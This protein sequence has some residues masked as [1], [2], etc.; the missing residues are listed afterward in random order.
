MP[1]PPSDDMDVPTIRVTVRKSFLHAELLAP[2]EE[3]APASPLGR[4]SASS[5]P[6]SA[7]LASGGAGGSSGRRRCA[8]SPR[9]PS[10][11]DLSTTADDADTASSCSFAARS[12]SSPKSQ[13]SAAPPSPSTAPAAPPPLPRARPQ[14]RTRRGGGTQ[15]RRPSDASA[16][17][18]CAAGDSDVRLA[19][20]PCWTPPA[21]ASKPA[22]AVV[23]VARGVTQGGAAAIAAVISAAVA[24]LAAGGSAEPR[25]TERPSG[26][27]TIVALR[28]AEFEAREGVL[29]AVMQGLLDAAKASERV[30]VLGHATNPF[31]KSPFGFAASL[32]CVDDE[33]AVCW[34]LVNQGF[35]R[36]GAS[37]Q[38]RHPTC[39]KTL[40]VMVKPAAG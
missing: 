9:A 17:P 21:T 23:A 37:C 28:P 35:C 13:E 36:R 24:C 7:R 31:V 2:A 16:A 10:W 29:S 26:W 3:G 11:A 4:A 18:G 14:Q 19:P 1:V 15:E 6:P 32:A 12:S 20:A 39:Q 27:T 30:Y 40:N 25:T 5:V 8:T 33:G 34:N 22:A 38:R